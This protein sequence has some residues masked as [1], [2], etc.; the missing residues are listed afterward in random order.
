MEIKLVLLQC[1]ARQ[2]PVLP[3]APGLSD[4][5]GAR[6]ERG[7]PRHPGQHPGQRGLHHA[8]ALIGQR[9]SRDL[10]SDLSLVNGQAPG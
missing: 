9:R 7:G 3:G 5:E 2:P 4:P 1:T 8:W 10:D 6:A